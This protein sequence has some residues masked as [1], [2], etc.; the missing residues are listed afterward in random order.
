MRIEAEAR[1][2][3]RSV[4][5]G[6]GL[7]V[8]DAVALLRALDPQHELGLAD[9]SEDELVRAAELADGIP[10][11]L[12]ILAGMLQDDPAASL[13]TLLSDE[14]ALGSQVVEGLVAEAFARL[15]DNERRVLEAMAVF[16]APVTEA[17]VTFVVHTWFPEIDVRASLRRLVA[18]H[19]T[20]ASRTSGEYLLHPADRGHAYARVPPEPESGDG[21]YHRAAVESRVAD[22]YAKVRL[23][24]S[25]WRSLEAVAPQLAEFE[26]R[27]RAGEVDRALEVL[28]LVDRD[29]LFLWGHYTR[30]LELRQLVVEVPARA[31]LR[32]ANFASL[33]VVTQVLGQYDAATDYYE[34]AVKCAQAVGDDEAEAEYVGHLGR[35]YR[36]LGYMDQAL[37]CSTKALSSAEQADDRE[38]VGRWQDRLGLVYTAL[39]RLNEALALH[40]EAVATARKFD[41]R[42]SQAAALSNLGVVLHLLGRSEM[43]ERAQ[44]D[45]LV[46]SREADD[47]RGDAII[48]GRQGVL[49]DSLGEFDEALALHEQALAIVLELGD[50]REQSS[51]L[52]GRGRARFALGTLAAAEA[53]FRAAVKLEMPETAYAAALGLGL[54]LT[55]CGSP[56]RAASFSHAVRRCRERLDRSEELFAARYALAVALAGAAACIEAW[57][58]PGARTDLL[59]PAL[60][61]L[62]RAIR[63]CDGPG[64]IAATLRDVRTLTTYVDGLDGLVS[65]L[66]EALAASRR[67]GDV[68]DEAGGGA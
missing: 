65:R 34:Q 28:D 16:D 11:A 18:S 3:V 35:L 14:R 54:L 22:Y 55:S 24:P 63:T 32:A 29:H 13:S 8:P 31:D 44:R 59:A 10:R 68:I 40:K 17:A 26:H 4:R 30:L 67:G 46:L 47:R 33:A 36:N 49:A 20:T 58:E 41:D 50:R 57:N 51:Q 48:L 64:A 7:P 39:G 53:D 61:E 42:R 6:A 43:A 19:F 37:S 5:L 25:A 9:A 38:A 1:P 15:D 12:E 23:P 45:A 66:Q 21:D 2:L 27:V 52:I 62:E 60:A 56:E